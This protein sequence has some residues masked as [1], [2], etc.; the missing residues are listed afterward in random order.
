MSVIIDY[1][2]QA[3]VRNE[4]KDRIIDPGTILAGEIVY[5]AYGNPVI[6]TMENQGTVI[7][8]L[9]NETDEFWTIPRG[10]H[11]GFGTVSGKRLDPST[12]PPWTGKSY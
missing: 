11:N 8:N 5:D 6:G 4:N 3:L 1:R 7:K 12:L 9:E 2:R 10:Y